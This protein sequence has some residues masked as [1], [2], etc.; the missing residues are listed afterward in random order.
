MTSLSTSVS[1]FVTTSGKERRR[2]TPV[3]N[4][5][6]ERALLSVPVSVRKSATSVTDGKE[7]NFCVSSGKS[8]TSV[9][10]GVSKRG[11]ESHSASLVVA[12]RVTQ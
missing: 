9:L 4:G 2:G 8:A 5:V 10:D 11:E 6:S 12:F 3:H 1:A 7:C